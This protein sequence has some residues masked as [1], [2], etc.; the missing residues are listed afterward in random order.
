MFLN[1]AGNQAKAIM[2]PALGVQRRAIREVRRWGWGVLRW[3]IA[4]L[5]YY[6]P[7]TPYPWGWRKNGGPVCA[8]V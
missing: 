8:G 6:H 1:I 3:R 4:R 5:I 2:L 7:P